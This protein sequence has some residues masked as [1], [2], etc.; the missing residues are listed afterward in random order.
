MMNAVRL[1]A[2]CAV[3]LA[4]CGGTR[5]GDQPTETTSDAF[6]E[7]SPSAAPGSECA[8]VRAVTITADGGG[9]FTFDVTVASTD[10]G[11]EKYA[12]AWEVRGPDGVV[13]GE[14]VLAHPHETEQPFTRSLSG[15]AIPEEVTEVTVAAHDLVLGFC[16]EELTVTVPH[17]A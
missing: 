15:V 2:A 3:L 17:E 9:T 13:L 5:S 1:A 14:R 8:H 10:T 7:T 6:A 16:G 12:D 4:A 11:W